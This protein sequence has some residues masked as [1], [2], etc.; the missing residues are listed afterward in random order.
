MQN[1]YDDLLMEHIKNA[2]NYRVLD[3][4]SASASGAN[5][6]CGDGMT[7]YVRVEDGRIEDVAFQ[8]ECCGVSMASAS[9]MTQAVLGVCVE[10]AK[11]RVTSF[12]ARV[13]DKA[14]TGR[15]DAYS[16]QGAVVATVRQYPIRSRCAVL[17][18]LTLEAA[19]DGS[20]ETIYVR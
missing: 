20:P 13:A 6:L 3:G 16:P 12:V 15:R 4:A 9:I 14:D 8:C 18:W 11:A 19:L 5:A 7:V 17:P 1:P 10:E 2:R